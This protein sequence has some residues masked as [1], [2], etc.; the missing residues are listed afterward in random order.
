ML[1]ITKDRTY[2]TRDGREARIYATD[3]SKIYSIHGAVMCDDGWDESTWTIYG[4]FMDGGVDNLRDLIEA[5]KPNGIPVDLPD[6]SP[7]DGHTWE[8]KGLEWSSKSQKVYAT[9]FIGDDSWDVPRIGLMSF[10]CGEKDL[11]Y[12][13]Y[14]PNPVEEITQEQAEIRLSAISGKTVKIIK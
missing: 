8:Y 4:D 1:N 10:P 2:T 7:L 11:F 14:I 6:P 5:L 9:A 12:V 13:E 3:G